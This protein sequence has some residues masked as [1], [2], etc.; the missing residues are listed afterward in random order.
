MY[1]W[2]VFVGQ[3]QRRLF[4]HH[5]RSLRDAAVTLRSPSVSKSATKKLGGAFEHVSL[6]YLTESAD[7]LQSNRLLFFV[8]NVYPLR[9][10]KFDLRPYFFRFFSQKYNHLHATLAKIVPPELT[11]NLRRVLPRYKDGGVLLEFSASHVSSDALL[12]RIRQHVQSQ[13]VPLRQWFNGQ[14]IE[15]F[16]VKV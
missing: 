7:L 3:H 6:E 16:A 12:Q 2:I 14:Q 5:G 4:S 15:T 10:Y 8:N 9:L 1:R 13:P 11:P